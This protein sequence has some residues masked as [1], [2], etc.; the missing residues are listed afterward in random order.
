MA[1]LAELGEMERTV[2]GRTWIAADLE[3]HESGDFLTGMIGYEEPDE[4][5]E[6]DREASSWL[7]SRR[8]LIAGA[9]SKAVV[10]FAVD[11]REDRRWVA[12]ALS[13]HIRPETFRNGLEVALNAARESIGFPTDWE[14]DLVTGK[15]TVEEWVRGHPEVRLFRRTMKLPNPPRDLSDDIAEMR[16]IRAYNRTEQ[17]TARRNL[18]LQVVD[19]EGNLTEVFSRLLDGIENGYIEVNLTARGG[20]GIEYK[21][22]TRNQAD[23]TYVEDFGDDWELGIDLV[24]AAL[25]EYSARRADEAVSQQQP[26]MWQSANVDGGGDG[27]EPPG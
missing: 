13:P 1:R 15:S 8:S 24:F 7:K 19:Q 23:G 26:T 25:R 5:V 6:Y 18:T 10:P 27:E 20:T 3:L 9:S 4:R 22:S 21:F 16:E 11:L 12:F 14:V 2:G 17:F